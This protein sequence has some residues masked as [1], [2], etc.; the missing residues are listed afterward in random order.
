MLRVL[1]QYLRIGTVFTYTYIFIVMDHKYK[2]LLQ[3][4]ACRH[5]ITQIKNGNQ[6]ISDQLIQLRK[7][8]IVNYFVLGSLINIKTVL[9][10]ADNVGFFNR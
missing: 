8:D 4:V 1:F 7:L 9:D 6:N 3:N 2:S 10:A 5:V